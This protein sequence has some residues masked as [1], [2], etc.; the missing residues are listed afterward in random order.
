MVNGTTKTPAPA[1]PP[2][3]HNP[4]NPSTPPLN[5]SGS[6]VKNLNHNNNSPDHHIYKNENNENNNLSPQW[7]VKEHCND[8]NHNGNY[9]TPSRSQSSTIKK[10][11]VNELSES[12]RA[13][14]SASYDSHYNNT[15]GKYMTFIS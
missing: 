7:F 11:N 2:R 5:N 4:N 10:Q 13:H 3:K 8:T 6:P 14:R 12:S 15:V 1:K 9:Q